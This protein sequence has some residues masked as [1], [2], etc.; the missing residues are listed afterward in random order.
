MNFVTKC[1]K[2]NYHKQAKNRVSGSYQ[3]KKNYNIKGNDER[4]ENE[5]RTRSN[6]DILYK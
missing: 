1:Q 5:T 3:T 4:Y 2:R 6:E